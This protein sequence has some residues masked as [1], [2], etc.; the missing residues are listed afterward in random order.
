MKNKNIIRVTVIAISATISLILTSL[1]SDYIFLF[2][3]ALCAEA[4][5]I[6]VTVK[7]WKNNPSYILPSAIV[8][9]ISVLPVSVIAFYRQALWVSVAIVLEITSI[10]L[11]ILYFVVKKNKQENAP[12]KKWHTSLLSVIIILTV[13]I[14]AAPFADG[15]R[16]IGNFFIPID[17]YVCSDIRGANY[18]TNGEY[19]NYRWGED[20]ATCFPK[21][22]ELEPAVAVDFA[23]KDYFFTE[24]YFTNTKTQYF[25]RVE[26]PQD[27][28]EAIRNEMQNQAL[29]VEE[30]FG[31]D[32]LHLEKRHLKFGNYLYYYACFEDAHNTVIYLA[33]I[34]DN[35]DCDM[36]SD[37]DTTIFH[38]SSNPIWQEL[39]E[40]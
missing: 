28:Y 11:F 21:L 36:F 18:Y 2:L 37:M 7:L 27:A 12:P 35:A 26:Y 17:S 30:Y 19:T 14:G 15:I 3:V 6:A 29:K 32:V 9:A 10:V 8:S 34:D 25:L 40:K 22:E 33:V 24:T 1:T 5:A 16:A 39:Y 38:I 23:H 13:T 31:S 20:V 4:L